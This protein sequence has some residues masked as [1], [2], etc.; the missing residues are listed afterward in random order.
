[1]N[2]NTTNG[3]NIS[4]IEVVVRSVLMKICDRETISGSIK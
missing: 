1:M 3:D 2:Q 4:K